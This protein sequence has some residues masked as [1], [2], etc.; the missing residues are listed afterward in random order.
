[1]NCGYNILHKRMLE[2]CWAF[3][4]LYAKQHVPFTSLLLQNATDVP[5]SVQPH[6]VHSL[7][8]SWSKSQLL[9]SVKSWVSVMEIVVLSLLKFRVISTDNWNYSEFPLVGR[10]ICRNGLHGSLATFSLLIPALWHMNF[11]PA[12]T[13]QLTSLFAFHFRYNTHSSW[14]HQSLNTVCFPKST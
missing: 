8:P 14:H 1:M 11:I 10:E 4:I 6:A 12:H 5:N 9:L 2:E 7:A 3:S 13:W